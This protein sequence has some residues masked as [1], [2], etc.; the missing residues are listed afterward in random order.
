MCAFGLVN[1][2]LG[3]FAFTDSGAVL[4]VSGPPCPMTGPSA[5]NGTINVS[6]TLFGSCDEIYAL[7]GMFTG[8]NTWT[9]TF[10]ATFVGSCFDCANQST[11]V[12]GQR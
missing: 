6:C 9:G 10:T 1:Y 2:N 3:T 12:T 8:P 7:S 4:V 5:V 11:P